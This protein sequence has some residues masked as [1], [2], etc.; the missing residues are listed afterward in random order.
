[1]A[2]TTQNEIKR[3]ADMRS[4]AEQLEFKVEKASMGFTLTRTA[5]YRV[6]SARKTSSWR[7]RKSCSKRGSCAASAAADRHR[8]FSRSSS[9]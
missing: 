1:M 4:L 8:V 7:R 5:D 6:R 3:E 9:A 2:A